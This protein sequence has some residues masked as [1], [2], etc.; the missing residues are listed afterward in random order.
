LG[1]LGSGRHFIGRRKTVEGSLTI[2]IDTFAR[3]E[4]RWGKTRSGGILVW[5]SWFLQREIFRCRYEVIIPNASVAFLV[6]TYRGSGASLGIIHCEI[7]FA[8]IRPNFGGCRWFFCCPPVGQAEPCGRRV[9]KLYYDGFNRFGCRLCNNLTYRS[10]Q[11]SGK[12]S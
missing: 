1:G 4:L 5:G 7:E 3:N 12:Y 8:S 11:E 2:K 9:T 6:L 10:C